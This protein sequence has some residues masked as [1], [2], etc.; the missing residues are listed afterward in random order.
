[1]TRSLLAFAVSAGLALPAQAFDMTAMTDE[2]RSAFRA[3]IREY[4]IENPEVLLEA[5]QVLF[6]Q[7]L[8][9][10]SEE[11]EALQRRALSLPRG[12]EAGSHVLPHDP[13]HF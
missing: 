12:E 8:F 9:L 3:E 7:I 2:E 1:M 10:F 4:L 6:V 13:F 5:I 11:S